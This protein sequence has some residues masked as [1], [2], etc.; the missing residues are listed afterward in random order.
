MKKTFD[1]MYQKMSLKADSAVEQSIKMAEKICEQTG[2]EFSLT[3][4]MSVGRSS[5]ADLFVINVLAEE[6]G[7]DTEEIMEL[8][9]DAQI[10]AVNKFEE[11]A[12]E[13]MEEINNTK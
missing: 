3:K 1:E 13:L 2:E 12:L 6:Y 5:Y 7:V 11:K 8:F 4:A 9:T 10:F